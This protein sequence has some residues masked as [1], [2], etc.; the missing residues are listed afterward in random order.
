MD[1]QEYQYLTRKILKLININLDSYK[2][3]QMRRRLNTFLDHTGAKNVVDYTHMLERNQNMLD[4]LRNFLT[5]NV[6]EFFRDT[7]PFEQL[8]TLILP[9]LLR[10]SPR[11]NIWSAGCSHGEEPYSIAMILESISPYHHHR[12]LATDIDEGALNQA[13]A[14][15]PYTPDAVKNVSSTFLRRYFTALN[16]DYLVSDRIRRRVELRQQN[17]LCDEFEHGFDLIICRNVTIYFTEEAKRELNQRFY[18]SLNDGGVL[19][20]GGTE[21]MLDIASV[22]FEA[23]AVSFYQKPAPGLTGKVGARERALLKT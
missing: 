6:S 9:Q 5:I 15:G 2:S 21:V 12:I 23:L 17:L 22:G 13:K 14:G 11:L 3:Q 18:H 1:D 7:S 10:N 20:I 4:E 16:G 19:F 8:R